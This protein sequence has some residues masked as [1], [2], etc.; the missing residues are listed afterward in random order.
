M[1]IKPNAIEIS[2]APLDEISSKKYLQSN[3]TNI[4][5][6]SLIDGKNFIVIDEEINQTNNFLLMLQLA[7]NQHKGIKI[8]PDNIWLLICQGI[9]NCVKEDKS[10]LNTFKLDATE[11]EKITIERNDFKIGEENPWEE[12]FSL[13]TAEINKKIGD[14]FHKNYVL[15]FSTS[16]VKEIAAFEIALM[17]TMSNYFDYE[18]MTLCGIP[19][20]ELLGKKEDYIKMK[21]AINYF[22]Q[23]HLTWWLQ[24]VEIIID[25]FIDAFDGKIANSFWNSIYK[26]ENESGGPYITGWITKFFPLIKTILVEENGII[27][28]NGFPYIRSYVIDEFKEQNIKFL[29]A[30]AKN[31]T[32]QNP[33]YKELKLDNFSNGINKVP[34]I[35]KYL[36][37]E[38]KM[39]FT[40]GFVGITQ[41]ENYLST[42]I[43]WIINK[44]N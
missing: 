31:P 21:E 19:E 44:I 33:E 34:F 1:I 41:F 40:A 42:E 10:L 15:N 22:K 13:F 9:A 39:N 36:D 37:K 29:S 26:E 7:F 11:K 24:E 5:S 35:W 28:E 43:N 12:I 23:F 6:S 16:T 38:I 30:I 17:D 8:S 4:E 3:F 2:I 32:L 14:D 25:N 27:H 18:F 20:I